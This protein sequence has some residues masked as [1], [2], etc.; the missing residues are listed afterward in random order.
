MSSTRSAP[1]FI[2]PA[3]FGRSTTSASREALANAGALV[4]V[5]APEDGIEEAPRHKSS[6][7]QKQLIGVGLGLLAIGGGVGTYLGVRSRQSSL[8]STNAGNGTSTTSSATPITSAPVASGTA[9]VGGHYNN[10]GITMVAAYNKAFKTNFENSQA[11]FAALKQKALGDFTS[12]QLF[13]D[14]ACSGITANTSCTL[15]Q[16]LQGNNVQVNIP[17]IIVNEDLRQTNVSLKAAC[18]TGSS[19][20]STHTFVAPMPGP[21]PGNASRGFFSVVNSP[22]IACT[23][24]SGA[25]LYNFHYNLMAGSQTVGANN[26]LVLFKRNAAG[27]ITDA[28]IG[29]NQGNRDDALFFNQPIYN[30][31]TS[32]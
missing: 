27:Q 11:G 22:D 6:T 3:P 28:L 32:Y 25:P 19:D 10:T 21:A 13:A 18:D 17:L 14:Y 9:I 12:L 4:H 24:A 15:S 20:T 1:L 31:Q 2:V 16:A 8:Q 23:S 7:R 5:A 29:V 26:S 30:L